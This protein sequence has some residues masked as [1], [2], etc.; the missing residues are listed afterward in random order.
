MKKSILFTVSF[1]VL[2]IFLIQCSKSNNNGNPGGSG[3]IININGMS[4]SPASKTVAK[5]TVVT[6]KNNDGSAH[7]AT[8]N[9]GTTFDTGNIA[10]G[11]TATYT[12]NTAGTFEYHCIIHGM[13]MAGTLIVTP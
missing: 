5:G 11:G 6:W 4:F 1:L 9:D 8:S 13:A 7:T 3:N 2:S 12:A 10:G